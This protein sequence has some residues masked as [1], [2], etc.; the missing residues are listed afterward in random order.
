[1]FLLAQIV[2]WSL[3]QIIIAVIVVAACIGILVVAC[4]QFGVAIPDWAIKIFW[5]VVVA[6]VAIVAIRFLLTM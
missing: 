6:C 4:K 3:G 1:M 2:G 5:I